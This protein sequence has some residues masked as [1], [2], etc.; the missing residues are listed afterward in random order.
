MCR[1]SLT[2]YLVCFWLLE[3]SG[4]Q[5][6][7]DAV[8]YLLLRLS[9]FTD[10]TSHTML[11][12]ELESFLDY[13]EIPHDRP[14][15]DML[16][17]LFVF[18]AIRNKIPLSFDESGMHYDQGQDKQLDRI[19]A[20]ARR[21]HTD[22]GYDFSDMKDIYERILA[23]S[24]FSIEKSPVLFYDLMDAVDPPFPSHANPSL[25]LVELM[26]QVS[27]MHQDNRRVYNPYGGAISFAIFNKEREKFEGL[28]QVK[29]YIHSLFVQEALDAFG[30]DNIRVEVCDSSENWSNDQFDVVMS[31]MADIPECG[32]DLYHF[33]RNVSERKNCQKKAVFVVPEPFLWCS[34]FKSTREVLCESGY[35]RHVSALPNDLSYS[36]YIGILGGYIQV[37]QKCYMI[38]L[39]YSEKRQDVEF[40]DLSFLGDN[41]YAIPV[42]EHLFETIRDDI[43]T[44]PLA[45]IRQYDYCLTDLLYAQQESSNDDHVSVKLS[46]LIDICE[47]DESNTV[48]LHKGQM[49]FQLMRIPFSDRVSDATTKVM[50]RIQYEYSWSSP[51]MVLIGPHIHYHLYGL[52]F[53]NKE[54]IPYMVEEEDTELVFSLKD[55]RVSQDYLTYVLINDRLLE[56]KYD[57]F[58]RY[59][60]AY[61]TVPAPPISLLLSHRVSILK[62]RGKQ[63]AVVARA[64]AE[65]IQLS[66]EEMTYNVVWMASDA[67]SLVNSNAK[68]LKEWK[69]EV[70]G[71]YGC[72]SAVTKADL[73][74]ETPHSIDAV[75]VDACI[76]LKEG[77]VDDEEFEGFER[78]IDLRNSITERVIP[79]YVYTP[80]EQSRLKGAF[81]KSRLAYFLEQ[82]RYYLSTAESALKLLVS[83]M[84]D[85]LDE[86]GSLQSKVTNKF[87][88][89]LESIPD[90]KQQEYRT[91]LSKCLY[92]E[93]LFSNGDVY[94]EDKFNSLRKIVEDVFHSCESSKI[95]PKMDFGA[96]IQFLSDGA[97][98]DDKR[99]KAHFLRYNGPGIFMHRTLRYSLTY[100]KDILNGGSHKDDEK[101]LDVCDYIQTYKTANLY[102]SAVY[103]ILDLMIWFKGIEDI[104]K[105]DRNVSFY[106]SIDTIPLTRQ[107]LT[108]CR[109]GDYWFAG[110]FHLRPKSNLR[111]GCSVKIN[112]FSIEKAPRIE[113]VV[114]YSDNYTIV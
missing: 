100:L 95:L 42:D 45:E 106:E 99:R 20:E 103:V 33:V 104:R 24:N 12:N 19:Y 56:K 93:F 79:F 25:V 18:R 43:R 75:I 91:A 5:P 64:V 17:V 63:D 40:A 76:P 15:G 94:T 41:S 11:N 59:K 72:A 6:L 38:E 1:A 80:V 29:S 58:H 73:L 90:Y 96:A 48:Q 70:V 109:E 61:E 28:V 55:D 62:D 23:D 85:E 86:I 37:H 13:Y 83:R 69:V 66:D 102:K 77:V 111:E 21:K 30:L 50:E 68:S 107:I 14:A 97:Y 31:V 112:K 81:R 26:S 2:S 8:S 16:P 108:A 52:A 101:N 78:I 39:D 98:V 10:N 34:I 49:N 105:A 114:F 32:I 4:Y 60:N 51:G 87:R 88:K 67:E 46:D 3:I 57:E 27:G 35:L 47:A 54:D 113:C 9:R 74:A 71:K 92:D 89:E 44:V 110:Q 65:S 7:A 36:P 82:D 53:S 84:R 22:P